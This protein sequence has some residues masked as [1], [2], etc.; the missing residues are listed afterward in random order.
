MN[1]YYGLIYEAYN[2]LSNKRY[3][4]Q[5]KTTLEKRIKNHKK[6]KYLKYKTYFTNSYSKHEKYFKWRVI[7]YCNSQDELDNCEKECILFFKSNDKLYGYN[8]NNG[9]NGGGKHNLKTKIKL[10][11]YGK[12][13]KNRNLIPMFAWLKENNG[14]I[15][16]KKF[17]NNDLDN[18]ILMRFEGKTSREIAK[19]FFV[20]RKIIERII[21]P[22]KINGISINNPYFLN[23]LKRLKL[24]EIILKMYNEK[25]TIKNIKE[26]LKISQK[27]LYKILKEYKLCKN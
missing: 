8:L 10:S 26:T 22:I 18:I 3:I 14:P 6:K 12:E 13:Q 5:T 17:S 9:G 1:D 20:S 27:P 11:K 7:G 16:K 19:K 4:G 24:E 2:T 15:N 21:K 25:S 23:Y